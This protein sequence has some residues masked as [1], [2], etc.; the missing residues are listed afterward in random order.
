MSKL[1]CLISEVRVRGVL[2]DTADTWAV[3]D[4]DVDIAIDTPERAP[5]VSHDV[6]GSIDA[7]SAI[8][9]D[10]DGV[11]HIEAARVGVK[12][13]AG[14][15][16]EDKGVSFECDR[17]WTQCHCC[18]HIGSIVLHYVGSALRSS[19]YSFVIILA[20]LSLSCVVILNFAI[21]AEISGIIESSIFITAIAALTSIVVAAIDEL[22]LGE[23]QKCTTFN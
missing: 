13:T 8:T 12:D 4:G 11:V 2:L 14:V 15:E 17:D 7:I 5:G 23:R 18:H 9:N 10:N 20:F 6:V 19:N 3:N 16:L 1:I 22:L 21:H